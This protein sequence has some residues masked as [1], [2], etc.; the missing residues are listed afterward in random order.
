MRAVLPACVRHG[1]TII[2]NMGAAHP[3]AAGEAVLEVA[4]ELGLARLRVA[5]VTGDDV[6]PWMLAHDVPLMDSSKTVRSLDGRLISANA[7]LGA[8]ALA[9]RAAGGC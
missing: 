1:V 8:D 9:A 5:V 4:R 2:T 6:L 7:Y 3:M